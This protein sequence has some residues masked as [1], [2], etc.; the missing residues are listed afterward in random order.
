MG[1]GDKVINI[2]ISKFSYCVVVNLSMKIGATLLITL[3]FNFI[4]LVRGWCGKYDLEF[5]A[6][7]SQI[8]IAENISLNL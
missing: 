2:G 4:D 6:G 5:F 3:I 7:W 8:N 1:C